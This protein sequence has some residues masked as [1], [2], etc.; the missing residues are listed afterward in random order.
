[1]IIWSKELIRKYAKQ[2]DGLVSVIEHTT[3]QGLLQKLREYTF[4]GADEDEFAEPTVSPWP[5]IKKIT[6]GLDSP[7]LNDGVV[8]VDL[9]G[10]RDS[11]STRR[12]TVGKALAECTHYLVV[13]QISRAQ[14]DDTVTKYFIEGHNKKGSG[15]VVA[16]ITNSDQ[17]DGDTRTGDA[18]QQKHMEEVKE[19]ILSIIGELDQIRAKKKT[20]TKQERFEIFEKEE[21][22]HHQ[23]HDAESAHES[24][25]IM[26]RNKKTV[27]SL[28][29]TYRYLTG[30]QR[31]LPIFCVS[32]KI[33]EQY[34][35]GFD[36]SDRPVLTLEDTE[37][38]KL[39]QHL[40]LATGEGRF[41][42]AVFHYETQLPSLLTS[43]DLWCFKAHMKRRREVEEIVLGPK[44]VR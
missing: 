3:T 5:L 30:D 4:N 12:R 16:A 13:A 41:N 10:V 6:F 11:N 15:R 2:D 19:K 36:R 39:R 21:E 43:V 28:R 27:K 35:I 7:M 8:L 18:T 37:I 24:S 42:D 31:A 33:Y 1:M 32:N 22:L 23:L 40:R 14:D 34:S 20:A 17:I 26:I 29:R 9:P 44:E 25:K 38:P